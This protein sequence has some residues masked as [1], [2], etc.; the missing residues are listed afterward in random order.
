MKLG[1]WIPRFTWPGTPIG[2]RLAEI[3]KLAESVGFESIW[4][5]DHFSGFQVWAT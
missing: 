1:L 5:M 3:G 4:L 2:P